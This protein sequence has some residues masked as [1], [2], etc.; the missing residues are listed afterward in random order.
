MRTYGLSGSGMDIDQMVKDSMK[1]PR[2]SYDKVWQK[3]TQ[4]EWKKADYNEVYTDLQKFRDTTV[5]NSRLQSNQ[6]INKVTVGND[7]VAS[8]TAASDAAPVVHTLE[9]S[10]LASGV[11]KTSSGNITTGSDKTSL[12]SQF[13]V[14]GTIEFKI[15]GKDISIDSSKSVFE[16]VGAINRSDSGVKANYDAT[17]DR[18]FLYS[19]K[20]GAENGI[21]FSGSSAEGAAFLQNN[22]KLDTETVMG[23]NAKFK[24]DGVELEKAGNGFSISGVT[25]NLKT[26]GTSTV[27]V[28]QD[29]DKI[30]DNIKSFVEA[31]NKLVDKIEGKVGEKRNRDFMPLTTD[32]RADM[33]ENEIKEWEKKARSGLLQREP[34]LTNILND[35]RNKLNDPVSGINGKYDTLAA[36]GIKTGAWNE[37]NKLN[38]DEEKLRQ[39]IADDPEAVSKLFTSSG[40]TN[41]QKGVAVRLYEGLKVGLDKIALEAG[42]T[43]TTAGDNDSALSKRIQNFNKQLSDMQSRLDSMQDRYYKKFNAM[44]TALAN[45]AKQSSWLTQNTG[46]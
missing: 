17:L 42:R 18:F 33:K 41:A 44:E 40:E 39:A 1:A 14:T 4:A 3:K 11:S 23:R 30:V 15:N 12:A 27:S 2:I 29:T 34:A 20:T 31:Y 5:F 8:A 32:Q 16:L 35:M 24:L 6:L 19:T 28:V 26:V 13:G 45:I 21:D 38:I 10:E 7:T 25:Y 9:V 36:I 43:A 22:L 37:G 46:G